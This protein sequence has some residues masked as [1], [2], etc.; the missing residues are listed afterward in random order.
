MSGVNS[1]ICNY[2][3]TNE[4]CSVEL[5][6]NNVEIYNMHGIII[7]QSKTFG[8]SSS[9]GQLIMQADGNLVVSTEHGLVWMSDTAGKG[10]GP[11]VAS[12]GTDCKLMVSDSTG[13]STWSSA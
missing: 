11:F 5:R 2:V 7:W 4:N 9:L 6:G 13:L 8:K 3:I 10:T 12:V 1:G